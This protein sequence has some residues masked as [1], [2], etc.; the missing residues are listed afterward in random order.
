MTRLSPHRVLAQSRA[1]LRD[2]R[3]LIAMGDHVLTARGRF[4]RQARQL[5]AHNEIS[6]L[7]LSNR[8]T[9]NHSTDP[10]DATTAA[11]WQFDRNA[12]SAVWR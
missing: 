2:D 10:G 11:V 9:H 7:G 5:L 3:P 1:D 8:G 4:G 6:S 12:Y